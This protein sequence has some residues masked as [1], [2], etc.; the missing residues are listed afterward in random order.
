MKQEPKDEP[1]IVQGQAI[2][3]HIGKVAEAMDQRLADQNEAGEGK[4]AGRKLL[5]FQSISKIEFE[6]EEDIVVPK[7]VKPEFDIQPEDGKLLPW[8]RDGDFDDIQKVD[9]M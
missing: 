8:E 9:K 4:A 6:M 7:K 5:N 1:I 3:N 2:E